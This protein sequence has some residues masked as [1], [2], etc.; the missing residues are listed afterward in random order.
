MNISDFLNDNASSIFLSVVVVAL[1]ITF[2]GK[3]DTSITA[4]LHWRR[5][6]SR[7]DPTRLYTPSQRREGMKK[8]S[9]RCEGTGLIFRCSYV[10]KD[11]QGDHWFPHSRGGSTTTR[12]LVMLCPEC[13]R[14]KSDR[15]PSRFQTW[16][17]RFRRRRGDDYLDS[18]PVHVGQWRPYFNR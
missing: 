18:I 17:L 11:L 8:C 3:I 6:E 1:V 5:K 4:L 9:Y 16:A 13:N 7:R 10:G 15:I 14:K 12:N 2:L